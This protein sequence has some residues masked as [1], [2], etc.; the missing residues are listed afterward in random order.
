[1][2]VHRVQGIEIGTRL[3]RYRFGWHSLR[4]ISLAQDAGA[5]NHD[6]APFAQM[7]EIAPIVEAAGFRLP[8]PDADWHRADAAYRRDRMLVD[9][10]L[11]AMGG[12]AALV[13]SVVMDAP[14]PMFVAIGLFV[15]AV[16]GAGAALYSWK[17]KRHTLDNEQII[18]RSG[19]LSPQV[20]IATRQKLHSVELAQGP[21]ARLRGYAT[22]KLGL[23]GGT[24][25]IPGVPLERAREVRRLCLQ[26]IT[27]TDF[28]RIG[29]D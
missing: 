21:L 22:I 19:L 3:L 1:M 8:A 12:V 18:A 9:G 13:A 4:F 5:A 25:D 20:Q 14:G 24:F 2:P 28:S 16:A 7:E 6:V 17:F 23:A 11:F 26:T 10:G 29:Q 27:A 15:L